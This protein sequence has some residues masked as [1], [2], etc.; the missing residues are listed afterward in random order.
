VI[1]ILADLFAY[2]DV[3]AADVEQKRTFPSLAPELVNAFSFRR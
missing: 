3:P 1:E 2:I